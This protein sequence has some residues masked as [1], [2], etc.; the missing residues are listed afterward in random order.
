M[1]DGALTDA[2]ERVPEDGR[3]KSSVQVAQQDIDMFVERQEIDEATEIVSDPGPSEFAV[4]AQA[5][6]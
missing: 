6:P 5:W 2:K 3:F 1:E 4:A